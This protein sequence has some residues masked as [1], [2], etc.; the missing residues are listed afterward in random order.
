MF[1]AQKKMGWFI[2]WEKVIDLLEKEYE[3]EEVRY[4][5]GVKDG[6][7][8]MIDFIKKLKSYGFF[9]VTKPLKKIYLESEKRKER[10]FIYKANFDVEISCDMVLANKIIKI[11]FLFSGDSDFAYTLR[12]LK[13]QKRKIFVYATKQTLSRELRTADYRYVLLENI[14]EEIEYKKRRPI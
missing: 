7:Q 4:Y 2:D 14:R 6:D 5:L 10:K 13:N 3:I 1:Y 12:L 11:M 8:K 9:V